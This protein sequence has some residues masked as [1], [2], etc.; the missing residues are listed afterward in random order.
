MRTLIA[1]HRPETRPNLPVIRQLV[2][3]EE[4]PAANEALHTR[5]GEENTGADQLPTVACSAVDAEKA[6][7]CQVGIRGMRP[8]PRL[9][10]R[11]A[12]EEHREASAARET[13]ENAAH[14]TRHA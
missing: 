10:T 11:H 5:S 1:S 4:D 2:V 14:R 12:V 13:L 6:G 8:H 3:A 7:P 9:A